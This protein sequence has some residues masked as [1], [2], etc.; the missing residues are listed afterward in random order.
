[1][2][3]RIGGG[4]FADLCCD[5]NSGVIGDDGVGSCGDGG[6]IYCGCD[7]DGGFDGDCVVGNIGGVGIALTT[8][9]WHRCF[10]NSKQ[11]CCGCQGC[12]L[13]RILVDI[14]GIDP[15]IIPDFGVNINFIKTMSFSSFAH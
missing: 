3:F 13:S 15:V 7:G 5:G 14:L 12:Q 11:L 8:S 4:N 1:M 6:F 2:I 9:D 10:E